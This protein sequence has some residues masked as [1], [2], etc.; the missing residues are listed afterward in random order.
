MKSRG[1]FFKSIE[2]RLQV[3]RHLRRHHCRR[4]HHY[5]HRRR[6]HLDHRHHHRR[7]HR[8]L[9]EHTEVDRAVLHLSLIHI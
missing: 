2:S 1:G 4:H 3:V 5:H 7:L 9:Q 8:L 6:Y